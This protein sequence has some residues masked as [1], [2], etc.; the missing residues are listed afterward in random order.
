MACGFAFGF[1]ALL[2][3]CGVP[4]SEPQ[5]Q[6][7]PFPQ[8]RPCPGPGPCPRPLPRP[9]P[10]DEVGSVDPVRAWVGGPTM[11]DQTITCNLPAKYHIHNVGGSDGAGLC[12]FASMHHAGVW[13]GEPVF[14][15]LFDWMRK[16]PGGGW[17]EKV[18][19]MVREYA[20]EKRLD[21]PDYIQV[22]GTDLELLE[23]VVDSGR[24]VG[25]TYNHSPSGRYHGARIAH[26][27][28]CVKAGQ[29]RYVILDNNYPGDTQYEWLTR[30]EFL[31][32]DPS[33]FLFLIPVNKI[34]TIPNDSTPEYVPDAG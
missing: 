19:R 11:F 33:W 9:W 6:P 25:M 26:M 28:N 27:V 2:T 5:P 1:A 29:D 3:G 17:P 31:S 8:P 34:W 13:Q 16:H 4:D 23:L 30:K 21:V 10:R 22:Q 14:T 18:D 15:G 32:V 12:V 24:M 20:R 7:P